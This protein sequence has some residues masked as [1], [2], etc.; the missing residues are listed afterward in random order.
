MLY[1]RAIP[2]QSPQKTCSGIYHPVTLARKLPKCP[3]MINSVIIFQWSATQIKVYHS[4][5]SKEWAKDKK[6]KADFCKEDSI[7][8]CYFDMTIKGNHIALWGGH[9]I[10]LA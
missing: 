7:T 4:E 8:H 10:V 1:N 3:P 6:Y 5:T 9:E 2:Q